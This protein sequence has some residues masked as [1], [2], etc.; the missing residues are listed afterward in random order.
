MEKMKEDEILEDRTYVEIHMMQSIDG[1][2]TG[3]FWKKPDV[4]EGIKGFHKLYSK[5]KSNAFALGRVTMAEMNKEKPD[6]SKYKDKEIIEHKDF[7][8][9][10][11]KGAKYYFVAYDTKGTLAYKTNV[12]NTAEWAKDGTVMMCQY[13]EVLSD[14]V[15][16]EYLHYCQEKRISYI[17]AGK[18]KIDIRTSLVKL[19]K[20]FGIDKMVLQGGPTL[21]GAFIS[22]DLIDAISIIITPCTGEGGETLF[23]PSKYVEFKLIEFEEL[24]NSNIWLHY[25]KKK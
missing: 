10:L 16:N 12:K 24:S 18:N 8:V 25:V 17:F 5:I 13:L 4:V 9:P 6:L 19:K 21:D 23:K 7:V 20:L 1:K 2:A 14:E 11:E 3:D 15:S 22:D